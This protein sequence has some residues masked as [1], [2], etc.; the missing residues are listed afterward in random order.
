MG[1]KIFVKIQKLNLTFCFFFEENSILNAKFKR[2]NAND[3]RAI[4]SHHYL[5]EFAL[6]LIN[7]V[8]FL[9]NI[10]TICLTSTI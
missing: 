9:I 4:W 10:L 7:F 5:F 6:I 2:I 8:V 1:L 3:L